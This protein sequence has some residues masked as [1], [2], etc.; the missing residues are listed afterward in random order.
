MR[1]AFVTFVLV[2]GTGLQ[3]VAAPVGYWR[4]EES[5]GA[6]LD[7]SG[8]GL[9]GDLI[10]GASR[11]ADAPGPLVPQSG[12]ANLQSVA[13]NRVNETFGGALQVDDPQQHLSFGS[14]SFTIEAWVKLDHL[15]G[16]T[17]DERQYLI[18]K[19]DLFGAGGGQD[20]GLL[21]AG[22]ELQETTQQNFGKD[23]NLTGRELALAFGNGGPTVLDVW[24]VTSHLEISDLGWN[25]ISVAYDAEN[26]VVRFNVNDAFDYVPFTDLGRTTS[27]GPLLVGA[28]TNA[29]GDFNQFTRGSFDELRISSGVV[30]PGQLL[31]VPEPATLFLGLAALVFAGRRGRLQN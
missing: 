31:N 15:S 16:R 9:D 6:T 3:V 17:R 27:S 24:S 12:A 10:N 4:F 19:K 7:S 8:N 21:V 25:F 5:G 22:A 11:E 30:P 29:Q 14:G 18:Q 23:T 28:H 1:L 26:Q 2:L 20:Y 13:V